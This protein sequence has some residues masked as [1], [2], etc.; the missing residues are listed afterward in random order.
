MLSHLK[1]IQVEMLELF[2]SHI[3]RDGHIASIDKTELQSNFSDIPISAVFHY[4][5]ELEKQNFIEIDWKQC[6]LAHIMIKIK[7]KMK[8]LEALE[9]YSWIK[10]G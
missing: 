7:F 6:N 4:M 2:K 3:N 10:N 1:P 9:K 8:T 5:E